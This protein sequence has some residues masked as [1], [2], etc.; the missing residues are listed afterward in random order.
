MWISRKLSHKTE[1]QKAEKGRITI[2][3]P[4]ALEAGASLNSRSL[5]QYAPYGYSCAAPTG[6]EVMLIPCSEGQA[7]LGTIMKGE[8][9][10]AGEIMIKS[11]G[12]ASIKLANDGCIYLNG[13]PFMNS[14]GVILTEL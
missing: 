11:R 8:G 9:L 5:I 14:A 2:S 1:N 13:Q 7:A 4:T 10:E 3:S 12:G 6:E